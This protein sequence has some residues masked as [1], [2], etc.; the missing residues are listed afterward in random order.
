MYALHSNEEY[1]ANMRVTTY[2]RILV[3]HV[4]NQSNESDEFHGSPLERHWRVE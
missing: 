2:I 4:H 1:Y 3:S